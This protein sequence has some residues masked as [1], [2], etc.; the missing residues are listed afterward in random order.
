MDLWRDHAP[1]HGENGTYSCDLYGR[2][3]VSVVEEHDPASPLFVY[4]PLHDTH[5]RAPLSFLF[6]PLSLYP[7]LSPALKPQQRPI[8]LPLSGWA[9][10]LQRTSARRSG[11]T[12]A[13]SS[14][15]GSSCSACSPA[16]TTSSASSSPSSRPS[17]CGR[18]PSCKKPGLEQ[19]LSCTG[20]H[21]EGASVPGCG[22]RTTEA[23]STGPPTTVRPKPTKQSPC[24]RR[25]SHP[26]LPCLDPRP[27]ARRKRHRLS[28]RRADGGVRVGRPAASLCPRDRAA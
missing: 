4:L 19:A 6:L 9:G 25:F 20:W 8:P 28:G 14:R 26:T 12:L 7:F 21:S 17:R 3:V 11:W 15:C 5:S 23:R 2:D 16:P 10:W 24:R 18:T 27:T 13:S 1:A 22:A